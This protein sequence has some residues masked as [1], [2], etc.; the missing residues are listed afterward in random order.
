[1]KHLDLAGRSF[2]RLQVIKYIGTSSQGSVWECQCSCGNSTVVVGKCLTSGNTKSC[3]CQKSLSTIARNTIH[4]LAKTREY[5]AWNQM[6]QRCTNPNNP[7]YS[8]YGGRGIKVCDAWIRSFLVFYTDMGIKPAKEYS[9][10][11]INND[12]NYEPDNCKWAT[13]KEQA[14]NRRSNKM[15]GGL[16]YGAN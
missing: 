9:I 5:A 11:R 4:N 3:G 16:A 15:N 10:E 7:G 2:G 1:M 13:K 8:Y 14:N 6:I 12:G